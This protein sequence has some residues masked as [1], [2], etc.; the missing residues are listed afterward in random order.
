M[1]YFLKV[2][3]TAL[4]IVGIAELGKKFSPLAAILASL[5]LTSILAMVWLYVNTQDIQKVID[6]SSHIFWAV[7]P[8]LIFFIVLPILLR[9]GIRFSIAMAVSTVIM[10]ISYSVYLVLLQRLGVKF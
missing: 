3:I 7:L 6:L 5:P 8:S 4:V 2:I 10:F 9:N 1:Q